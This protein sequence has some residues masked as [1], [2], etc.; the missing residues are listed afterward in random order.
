MSAE[1]IV[2]YTCVTA[3]YDDL[4]RPANIEPGVD[5]VC[6]TDNPSIASGVW[7]AMP[8][9]VKT[10][11]AVAD[12]R[13]PKMHP[14]RLFPEHHISVYVDGNIEP[15]A[16]VE[17]LARTA[18]AQGNIAL[19]EHPFRDC[20]YAE[21]LECSAIGFDW[22][23]RIAAQTARYRLTRFPPNHGLYEAGI[24]IRRHH[25]AEISS[26][27]QAWWGAYLSGVR[28]DQLSLPYVAWKSG[29]EIISLGKSDIRG[30]GRHFAMRAQHNGRRAL[31]R[32]ARGWLN[33]RV[34]IPVTQAAR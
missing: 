13:F 23:W 14:H 4:Q 32:R 17:A 33:R 19:Y 12:S 25:S 24:I 30:G 7:K 20:V 11:D 31:A 15:L 8:L 34:L 6:I 27:M 10:G 28:R 3:G 16:G 5:Y 21:A 29:I 1:R 26:L 2:V 18:M 9:P 22:H